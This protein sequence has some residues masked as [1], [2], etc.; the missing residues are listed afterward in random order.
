MDKVYIIGPVGSGKTT[1]AQKMSV[2]YEIPMFQLDKVVWDDD[3][4]NIKRSDDEIQKLFKE[5]LDKDSWIIEDV[6]RKIFAKGIQ[7]ADV[8]YYI[9]L[10]SWLIYKRCISRWIKQKL[11]KEEYNYKPTLRGLIQMIKWAHQDIKNKE[12]KIKRIKENSKKYEII[13]NKNIIDRS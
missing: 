10:P 8:V 11:G 4:G 13:N 6:G 2:K 1:L 3:C 5:I 12:E 7:E 9:N